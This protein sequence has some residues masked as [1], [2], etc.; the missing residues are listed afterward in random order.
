[1]S[2]YDKVDL[3]MFGVAILVAISL[4]QPIEKE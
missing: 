4:G 3:V 1:M 2:Y